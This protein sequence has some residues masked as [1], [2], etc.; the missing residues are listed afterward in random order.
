MDS[1]PWDETLKEFN[2]INTRMFMEWREKLNWRGKFDLA[3]DFVKIPRYKRKENKG[4]KNRKD[5]KY[6]VKGKAKDGTHHAHCFCTSDVIRRDEKFTLAVRPVFKRSNK[7]SVVKNVV[8][9]AKKHVKIGKIFLDKE[10]Y[11]GKV[12]NALKEIGALYVIAAPMNEGVKK[13]IKKAKKSG[14]G[15]YV[16]EYTVGSGRDSAKTTLVIV[17]KLRMGEIKNKRAKDKDRFFVYATSIT[18]TDEEM[19]YSLSQ[20]YRARWGIETGYRVKNDF[21]AKN[22]GL[23][24]NVRFFIM[25]TA[26]ILYNLWVLINLVFPEFKW[27]TDL[28]GKKITAYEMRFVFILSMILHGIVENISRMRS[29]PAQVHNNYNIINSNMTL[30]GSNKFIAS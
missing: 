30:T 29:V 10:Y 13:Q 3:I 12:I 28:F 18:I 8:Q 6:T 20:E 21:R 7:A 26:V 23:S 11:A 2:E 1:K 16:T 9:Y 22:R 5:L 24:Y 4:K 19:A 14:K 25:I 27:F 15:C 17:D